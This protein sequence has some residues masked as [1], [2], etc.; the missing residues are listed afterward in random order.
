MTLASPRLFALVA[1]MGIVSVTAQTF[2]D[3]MKRAVR[4]GG[5]T[6]R[7]ATEPVRELSEALDSLPSRHELSPSQRREKASLLRRFDQGLDDIRE[8]ARKNIAELGGDELILAIQE[9][10]LTLEPLVHT[11]E[12]FDDLPSDVLLERYVDVV[13]RSLSAGQSYP[14]FD[15]ST[16]DLAR[17]GLEA[18]YFTRTEATL[19]RGKNAAA[20]TGFIDRLPSFPFAD[21]SEVL[22]IRQ[23][24]RAPLGRFRKVVAGLS[25]GFDVPPED[26]E[27]GA[28]LN[29]RWIQEVQPA[30]DE[31]EERVRQDASLR[32]LTGKFTAGVVDPLKSALPAAG[33]GSLSFAAGM[34]AWLGAAAVIGAAA[35]APTVKAFQDRRKALREIEK[36]PY[37]FLYSTEETVRPQ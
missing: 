2:H 14:L 18:G 25:S 31:I 11:E 29:A 22:D 12:E 9:G 23:E 32:A 28:V 10:V 21:M 36:H 20:G 16:G 8:T 1:A 6:M 34:D 4:D 24:L 5:E 30:L 35:A 13:D 27:F 26:P 37:F 17:L 3:V 33:L 19:A 15:A 7:A